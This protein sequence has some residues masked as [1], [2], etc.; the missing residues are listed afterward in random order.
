MFAL[1]VLTFLA[2]A[3]CWP[4][5]DAGPEGLRSYSCSPVT[6]VAR[7]S[8]TN[9]SMRGRATQVVVHLPGPVLV[10]VAVAR[11]AVS[12][13][14]LTG[15]CAGQLVR[16]LLR[17]AVCLVHTQ[18]PALVFP[19]VSCAW[20]SL[21]VGVVVCTHW[22][23]RAQRERASAAVHA[24]FTLCRCRLRRCRLQARVLCPALGGLCARHAPQQPARC[25]SSGRWLCGA[26]FGKA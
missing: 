1:V 22:L 11:A 18:L 20:L 14:G 16:P 26:G 2:S 5:G 3:L 9:G 13:C 6:V 21:C 8:A 7:T 12:C 15:G 25:A 4:R 23:V 24:T 17:F 10:A 19:A